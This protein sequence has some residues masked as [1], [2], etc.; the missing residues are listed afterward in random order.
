MEALDAFH[1]FCPIAGTNHDRDPPVSS[2]AGTEVRLWHLRC[3]RRSVSPGAK[4]ATLYSE[5]LQDRQIID[6]QLTIR[7][8]LVT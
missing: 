4:C 7:N 2:A 5:D 1:V 3:A 8:P 6:G